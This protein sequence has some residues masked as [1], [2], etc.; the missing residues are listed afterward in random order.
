MNHLFPIEIL[1]L[2]FSHIDNPRLHDLFLYKR[3]SK[4]TKKAIEMP[5]STQCI[6]VH[7]KHIEYI[8]KLQFASLRYI[9]V[10]SDK[11]ITG[12]SDLFFP[13]I[14]LFSN[15]TI[16]INKKINIDTTILETVRKRKGP[17]HGSTNNIVINNAI[18]CV[19]FPIR[20]PQNIWFFNKMYLYRNSIS[21]YDHHFYPI[22]DHISCIKSLSFDSL[23]FYYSYISQ[24][25]GFTTSRF[26]SIRK[27]TIGR[28]R[29]Y[30]PENRADFAYLIQ[31][32]IEHFPN[33]KK[34]SIL[35]NVRVDYLCMI[36]PTNKIKRIK[37]KSYNQIADLTKTNILRVV[38]SIGPNITF[39]Y[40]CTRT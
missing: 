12:N 15:V 36:F 35:K 28:Y 13:L 26:T 39:S 33:T 11:H 27:I 37:L 3:I 24:D 2:I 7:H 16:I 18:V 29:D 17:G 31:S 5:L 21:S 10:Y 40:K 6:S 23:E 20:I 19:C 34:I 25:K 30:N 1:N 8:T 22:S 38:Q 14:N 32:I 9:I 4:A